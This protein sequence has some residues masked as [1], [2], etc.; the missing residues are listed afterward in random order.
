MTPEEFLRLYERRASSRSF[1]NVAPLI[2]N[3]AVFWFNDGSYVGT[4]SI[5]KAFERTWSFEI[6]EEKY[7]LD[8]IRWLVKEERFAVCTFAYHWTG[9]V[10]GKFKELGSGRGTCVL[11]RSASDWKIIHEHLSREPPLP[12]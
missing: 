10:K 12:S 11:R 3:D 1:E 4:E 6:L 5:R 2:A 8:G 9:V 7:W